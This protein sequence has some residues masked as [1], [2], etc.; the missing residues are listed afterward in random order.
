MN[1]KATLLLGYL[2]TIAGA[3]APPRA[4]LLIVQSSPNHPELSD[5]VFNDWY[6]NE[7]VQDMVKSTVTDLVV[8][9]KNVN[10][11]AKM[12]IS[13]NLSHSRCGKATRPEDHGECTCY[14]Q[15]ATWQGEG[16][17]GRCLEGH[18]EN[19]GRSPL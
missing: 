17:Q 15:D 18:Y 19:G 8:R 3:Q 12:A 13:G 6:S 4:G 14:I 11:T 7:H 5:K 16:N 1:L 2:S 10:S 9:Y